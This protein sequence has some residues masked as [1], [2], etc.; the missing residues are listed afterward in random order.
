[1]IIGG[2][3]SDIMSETD[4]SGEFLVI[5]SFYHVYDDRLTSLTLTSEK[6]LVV[7]SF[8]FSC[9]CNLSTLNIGSNVVEIR[10]G[11]FKGCFLESI[12]F[13]GES[14]L[15]SIGDF[16]IMHAKLSSITFPASLRRIGRIFIASGCIDMSKTHI[17]EITLDLHSCEADTLILPETTNLSFLQEI[18]KCNVRRYVIPEANKLLFEEAAGIISARSRNAALFSGRKKK[19]PFI[20]RGIEIIMKNAFYGKRIVSIQIPASVIEISEHAFHKSTLKRLSFAPDSRLKIIRRE[21]FC[22]CRLNRITFPKSLEVIERKAFLYSKLKSIHFPSNSRVRDLGIQCFESHQCDFVLNNEHFRTE[23][24]FLLSE[25]GEHLVKCFSSDKHVKIPVTVR[26]IGE[27]SFM[28]HSSI[29]TVHIPRSVEIIGKHAFADTGIKKITFEEDSRLRHIGKGAFAFTRVQINFPSSLES[30]DLEAFRSYDSSKT[31]IRINS[32][33]FKTDESG[34]VRCLDPPGIVYAPR[35]AVVDMD[36]VVDVYSSAFNRSEMRSLSFPKSVKRIG[37]SAFSNTKLTNV[38]FHPDS[39]IEFIGHS[40]FSG[41][42]IEAVLLP[43]YIGVIKASCFYSRT[44]VIFPPNFAVN[45]RRRN[46]TKK[47]VQFI[48]KECT[49][50]RSSLGTVVSLSIS[51]DSKFTI[52][53]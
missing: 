27:A 4:T 47:A 13:I 8:A 39:E 2:K 9:C 33:N 35:D 7:D 51:D 19:F 14:R 52:L 43:R 10:E 29:E 53:D 42:E 44:I 1:M 40:A 26:T 17:E 32:R 22:C 41:S 24:G 6:S 25:N 16:A 36:G 31:P 23:D 45:D 38:T 3:E 21:A 5:R 28:E 20:R 50:P 18:T 12:R 46:I 30:L 15:V 11:A 48:V 37:S 49:I 34:I